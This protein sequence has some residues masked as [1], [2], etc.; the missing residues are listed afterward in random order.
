MRG[1]GQ[2]LF[3]FPDPSAQQLVP[4]LARRHLSAPAYQA[5]SGGSTSSCHWCACCMRSSCSPRV[6]TKLPVPD[7]LGRIFTKSFILVP[8]LPRRREQ[9]QSSAVGSQREIGKWTR[10]SSQKRHATK[11]MQILRRKIGILCDAILKYI[12]RLQPT[13]ICSTKFAQST[14]LYYFVKNKRE[15]T[16]AKM[17]KISWQIT[18]AALMQPLQYDL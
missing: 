12:R 17:K 5:S 18:I 7:Q 8:I 4:F 2:L 6:S 15:M 11:Q 14:S 3:S 1:A 10:Y 16:S 9:Q 13:A